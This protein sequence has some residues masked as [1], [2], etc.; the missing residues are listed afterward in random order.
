[1]NSG[2]PHALVV[3]GSGMLAGLCVSLAAAGREV[4]VV[5]RDPGKLDRIARRDPRIH[6]LSVDYEDVP[7]FTDALHDVVAERG[8]ITLAVCWIRS[9][10]PQSLLA[11]ADAVAPGGRLFH[12]LGSQRSDVTEAIEAL[13][14][15]EDLRYR[16]VQLGEVVSG[17]SRRWLSNDEI[18]DGVAAAVEA[19][20]PSFLVST[21]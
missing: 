17:E 16:Q 7:A 5:G 9:W 21:R 3:G 12:V 6:P 2:A 4:T 20:L 10:A 1:V 14:R 8:P 11:A 15:R 18:A 13:R 19:D